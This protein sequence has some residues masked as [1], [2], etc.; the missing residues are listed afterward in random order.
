MRDWYPHYV[1]REI[2]SVMS[3]DTVSLPQDLILDK[4]QDVG[5]EVGKV[6]EESYVFLGT[7][8]PRSGLQVSLS[9]HNILRG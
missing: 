7:S 8:L 5:I 3:E 1:L 9:R 6:L 2:V 4:E